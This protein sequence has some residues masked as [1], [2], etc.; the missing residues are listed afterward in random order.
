MGG[1]TGSGNGT[2]RRQTRAFQPGLQ[3]FAQIPFA[4]KQMW[5]TRDVSHKTI[6]AITCD[7]WR[8]AT[9]PAAKA[10]EG[11][12]LARKVCRPRRKIGT[13]CARIGKSHAPMQPARNG[14]KVG[15]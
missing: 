2:D 4:A 14:R 11:R 6:A 15:L 12:R 3:V 9:G 8:V 13:N 1:P 7:H 5:H 10:G